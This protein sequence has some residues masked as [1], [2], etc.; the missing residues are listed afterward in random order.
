MQEDEIMSVLTHANRE[1]ESRPADERLGSL[2]D[3]HNAALLFRENAARA[4]V[5]A[6]SLCVRSED[7]G[8]VITGSTGL[9]ACLTHFSFGQLATR[10]G[11]PAGYLH[12]LPS[13]LAA[14]CMNA[15]L[16]FATGEQSMLLFDRRGALKLRG[17]TSEKYARI[18]N[19]DVTERL[20]RLKAPGNLPRPRSTDR[21]ACILATATC[22]H[23]WST[24]TDASLRRDPAAA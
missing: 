22:S 12:T 19:C 6:T 7:D 17:I 14:D 11:A 4:I 9:P 16:K 10:A 24:T 18:W 3:M 1:W 2:K 8:I 20:L 23:S 13:K 15:G 21:A 5:P